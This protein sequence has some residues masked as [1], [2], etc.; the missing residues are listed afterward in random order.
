MFLIVSS[1]RGH[2]RKPYFIRVFYALRA[3]D[4]DGKNL[5]FS[6]SCEWLPRRACGR[7]IGFF[8]LA[9]AIIRA[10]YALFPFVFVREWLFF[11][12]E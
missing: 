12:L 3:V 6:T 1:G 7:F 8:P 9:L 10:F 4:R 5:R 11:S 2:R